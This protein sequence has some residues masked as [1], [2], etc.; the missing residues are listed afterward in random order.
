MST[1]PAI[2]VENLTKRFGSFV[3]VDDITF[4]AVEGKITALL[5]PSGSGKSTVLRMIAGLETPTAGRIW[6]E[7]EETTFKS[8][9]E[10]RVGFVFQ[11][12]AL[13][14]HMTVE[15][16][17]SFGLAVRK[18]SKAEQTRR[19][20]ELLELVQLAPF[21]DRYPDQLSGGQRQRVALARALAPRPRVLLLDEPFGAL[22]ARVRQDLRHWLDDLHREL[23]VTS[24]LVTHDQDE[25]LELA[26]E[27]VVMHEGH[28]EQMGTPT[29]IYNEPETAFVAGFVGSAN[30]LHG[31]V[32]GGHV[33]FG[34]HRVAG[35][36]HLE[37]GAAAR[38]FVRPHDVRLSAPDGNGGSVEARIDRVST[39]GWLS[40]VVLRLDDGQVLIAELSNDELEG[41]DVGSTVRVD[42]RRAKAFTL[43]EDVVEVPELAGAP[44]E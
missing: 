33:Q 40:R 17:V 36:G 4:D 16:N 8:V 39:L 3:A 37:E 32:V 13:F 41:L 26:H 21:R 24:L 42:L 2:R 35:A 5:G 34:G 11:H 1:K 28:I 15:Q 29:E 30:V 9:Q 38:A 7:D 23:G 27:V 12:Y 14:R 20:A 18:E 25:A 31:H 10:R 22:D 6:M 43:P 19:V 44:A